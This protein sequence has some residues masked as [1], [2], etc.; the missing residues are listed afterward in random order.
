[1]R[2]QSLPS[3]AETPSFP[4]HE[5]GFRSKRSHLGFLI[6]MP[7]TLVFSTY[8]ARGDVL[9]YLAIA[10]ELRR[11]GHRALVATSANYRAEIEALGLKFRAVLPEAPTP[12]QAE[13]AMHRVSGGESLFRDLLLPPLRESVAQLREV[14]RQNEADVL[15]THSTSFAGPIAAQLEAPRGLRWASS[16]VSPLLLFGADAAI[17]AAPHAADFPPLNR[18]ILGLLRRQFG[19]QLK[20]TQR[21]RAELGLSRGDNAL[22]SDAHSPT[23]QL[24]LWPDFFAPIAADSP[25]RAVGFCFVD[26]EK[27]LDAA[28][29]NFLDAGEAPLVFVAASFAASPQWERECEAAAQIAGKRAILLGAEPDANR[30]EKSA[31]DTILRWQ[32]APLATLLPR[33]RALIHAGGIGTL[34]LGLRAATPM[35]LLPR[36][37]DQFDN[38]RRAQKLGLAHVIA[39][40]D[41]R[42]EAVA[43]QIR[44][45][46]DDA[47]LANRLQTGRYQNGALNAAAA[48][49]TLL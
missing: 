46:L 18:A 12:R 39:S 23:M 49:E 10:C 3:E 36:A 44:A 45:L 47:A 28:L 32:F 19:M 43:R 17:P 22:W 40:R 42:A 21:I 5:G 20:E 7:K 16:A 13:K 48:L 34:A 25:R 4:G 1:M 24:A 41:K 38:A 33:V 8:G 11:R 31:S 29:E 2:K 37:H 26:A 14:C 6:S 15:V 27:R 9:P 35:L 30:D